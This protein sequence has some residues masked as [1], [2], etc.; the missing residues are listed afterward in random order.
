MQDLT[1]RAIQWFDDITVV[2]ATP[3]RRWLAAA[4]GISLVGLL[5]LGTGSSGWAWLATVPAVFGGLI[6]G[7]RFGLVTGVTAGLMHTMIDSWLGIAPVDGPGIVLRSLMLVGLAVTGA[8]IGRLEADKVAALDRAARED[9]VTGLLNVRAFYEG[10]EQLR[11]HDVSYSILLA[12]ISGTR[13][14]NERYGHMV[15]T[16]AVRTLG[17]VLRRSTKSRDLVGRLGSDNLAIALVGANHAGAAAAARRL[18]TLLAE[19]HIFLPDGEEF[20]VHAHYGVASYPDD[21]ADEVSL[22]RAADHA[23]TVAKGRGVD[24]VAFA[25]AL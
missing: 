10:L 16:D 3:Y 11:L 1:S 18:A 12:D 9:S 6:G 22:L 24:Q 5:H 20:E 15:G 14:L 19:E 13:G 8:V 17:H 4:V 7:V 21:A 2:L 25:L 23:V